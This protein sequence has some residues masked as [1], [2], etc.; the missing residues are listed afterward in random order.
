L[1]KWDQ[2]L[3]PSEQNPFP[4]APVDAVEQG[5]IT[6]ALYAQENLNWEIAVSQ[7]IG[8][9]AKN[10][11]DQKLHNWLWEFHGWG[12]GREQL[13]AKTV[14]E[15]GFSVLVRDNSKVACSNARAFAEKWNLVW[16]VEQAEIE[17][18]WRKTWED[19]GPDRACTLAIVS[20]QVLQ[21]STEEKMQKLMKIYA[22]F[23]RTSLPVGF[24]KRRAYFVHAT[25]AN[26]SSPV[27]WGGKVFSGARWGDTTP[28]DLDELLCPVSQKRNEVDLRLTE[29]AGFSYFH[30]R[31]SVLELTTI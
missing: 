5:C 3:T 14:T 8:Q 21:T 25:R 6:Q 1:E 13:A 18:S 31:Y 28:Y 29:I 4:L 10:F 15:I 9:A 23:V 17:K 19:G 11:F 12:L 20:S 30:Q 16:G 22:E 2:K 7:V 24:P 26:N 27:E